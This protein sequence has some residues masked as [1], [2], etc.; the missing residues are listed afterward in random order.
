MSRLARVVIFLLHSL[1][2]FSY[3]FPAPP[4]SLG[5]IRHTERPPTLI[6][7][8]FTI[9]TI[10]FFRP[11]SHLIVSKKK[12]KKAAA[13]LAIFW[14]VHMGTHRVKTSV[15]EVINYPKIKNQLFMK[16]LK[17]N[18]CTFFNIWKQINVGF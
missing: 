13:G 15:Q 5:L 3:L 6:P 1:F 16:V 18:V 8:F 7:I 9:S 4:R 17:V 10:F 12:K 2:F 11:P 14:S